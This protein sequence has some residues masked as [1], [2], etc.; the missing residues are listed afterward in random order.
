M[1]IEAELF[2]NGNATRYNDAKILIDL[3]TMFLFMFC[4]LRRSCDLVHEPGFSEWTVVHN[5][6]RVLL[7]VGGSFVALTML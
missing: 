5:C 2:Y 1:F 6:L 7:D 4:V 3:G